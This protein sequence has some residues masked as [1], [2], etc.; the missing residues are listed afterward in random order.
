[1]YTVL[2]TRARKQDSAFCTTS[3]VTVEYTCKRELGFS[4]F[5]IRLDFVAYFILESIV[6]ADTAA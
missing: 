5:L 3:K 2:R 4:I 1:M 6:Q